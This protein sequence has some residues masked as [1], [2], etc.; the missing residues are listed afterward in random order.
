VNVGVNLA[1]IDRLPS[2]LVVVVLGLAACERPND[3]PAL[4]DEALAIARS[5]EDRFDE[6]AHRAAAIRREALTTADAQKAYERATSV[7]VRD[8]NDVR[9]IPVRVKAGSPEELHRLVEEMHA[10]FERGV[11]EANAELTAVESW[12]FQAARRPPSGPASA[13]PEPVTPM[14]D[15]AE[16][17]VEPLEPLDPGAPIR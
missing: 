10:R 11:T 14:T 7:L 3:L 1:V 15:D 9:Q 8:R 5:Y 2:W 6:L 16:P 13:A 12:L 17:P 4:Q